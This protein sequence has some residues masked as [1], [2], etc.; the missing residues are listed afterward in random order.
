MMFHFALLADMAVL[1]IRVSLR[2]RRWTGAVRS[3]IV[4]DRSGD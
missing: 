3:V 2:L 1:S 4:S